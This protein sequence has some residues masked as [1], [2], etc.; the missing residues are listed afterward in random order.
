MLMFSKP[1]AGW[2]SFNVKKYCPNIPDEYANKFRASYICPSVTLL[3]EMF[4]DM[5]NP[6]IHHL[7]N[8]SFDAEGWNWYITD[9]EC[10][11]NLLLDNPD[12]EYHHG[13][14]SLFTFLGFEML[15]D[16]LQIAEDWVDCYEAY[17][18]EWIAFDLCEMSAE[19]ITEENIRS[20]LNEF[21]ETGS[22]IT[23]EDILKELKI[24]EEHRA[25]LDLLCLQLKNLIKETKENSRN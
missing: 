22:N 17:K 16:N 12:E 13:K 2:T 15:G 11:F 24:I 14:A 20:R 19:C 21:K 10:G 8:A 18:E 25:E 4:L 9:T 23:E 6:K 3:F 5:L 7:G 1:E